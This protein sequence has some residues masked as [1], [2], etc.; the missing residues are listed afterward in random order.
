MN[1]DDV[2]NVDPQLTLDGWRIRETLLGFDSFPEVAVNN[3]VY[4]GNL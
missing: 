1:M 3:M 2:Y 4:R